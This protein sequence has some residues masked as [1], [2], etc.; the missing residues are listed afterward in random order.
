MIKFLVVAGLAGGGGFAAAQTLPSVNADQCKP[1]AYNTT[2]E[3]PTFLEAEPNV[4]GWRVILV[5]GDETISDNGY[6][7]NDPKFKYWDLTQEQAED[8]LDA[9]ED[10]ASNSGDIF[11]IGEE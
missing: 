6:V 8:L 5:C 2:E 10:I 1:V 4:T 7:S 11:V 9:A 3:D